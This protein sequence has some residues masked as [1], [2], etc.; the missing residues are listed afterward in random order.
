M[1]S[2][3]VVAMVEAHLVSADMETAPLPVGS[4]SAPAVVVSHWPDASTTAPFARPRRSAPNE[5]PALAPA[6]V[7]TPSPSSAVR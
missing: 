2:C 5:M 7:P 4:G 6:K 1:T 3:G